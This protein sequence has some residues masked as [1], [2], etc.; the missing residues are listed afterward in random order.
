MLSWAHAAAPHGMLL[1]QEPLPLGR[2]RPEAGQQHE[3]CGA[4]RVCWRRHGI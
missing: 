4:N 2:I 1:L 3:G